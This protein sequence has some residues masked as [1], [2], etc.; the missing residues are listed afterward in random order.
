MHSAVWG[1][2]RITMQG[3]NQAC[4]NREEEVTCEWHV[5]I[6]SPHFPLTLAVNDTCLPLNPFGSI[7]EE[8][9]MT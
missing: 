4:H 1:K 5:V 7:Q 9:M 2:G 3:M 6:A 8:G